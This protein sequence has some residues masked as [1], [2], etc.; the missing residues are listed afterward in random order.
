MFLRPG[1]FRETRWRL[2]L[3]GP[4]SQISKCNPLLRGPTCRKQ[5]SSFRRQTRW[6]IIGSASS[7][8]LRSFR[9]LDTQPL[10][11]VMRGCVRAMRDRTMSTRSFRSAGLG[12]SEFDVQV[13]T[14]PLPLRR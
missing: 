1:R 8:R 12:W 7:Q 13:A 5:R 3:M 10:E 11:R 6:L 4:G 9:L 14:L 2:S